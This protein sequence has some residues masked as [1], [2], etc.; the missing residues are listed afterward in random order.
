M[1]S[2]IIICIGMMATYSAKS[3]T[4]LEEYIQLAF[5]NNQSIR[6]Q[7]FEF[8]KSTLA[9]KEAK[10]LF[11]PTVQLMSDYFLAGGGRTVDFPAGDLLNP[12][13]STLNQLTNAN[14][15]PQLENQRIL[16]NPNNFY[17]VKIR[18]S[19]PIINP[20]I[21]FN[22]IIKKEQMEL[23][24]LQIDLYKRELAK[25]IKIAYFNYLKSIQAI[26]IYSTALTI[27]KESRRINESLFQNDKV[28]RTVVI[29][30]ENEITKYTS[31]IDI[32]T[33]KSRSAMAYFNFLLNRNL[34]ESIQED[35][36]F[37]L[38]ADP[39]SNADG[40]AQ[41][42]E[43]KQLRIAEEIHRQQLGL[44]KTYQTPKLNAFLDLGSQGFDGAINRNTAYYFVGLSLQWDLFSAGRNKLKSQQAQL[45]IDINRSKYSY[46]NQQFQL[47][48]STSLHRLAE[49]ASEY[50]AALANNK[51][52]QKYY[53]DILKL[54]KEGQVLYI[55]LLDAQNQLIQS[56]LQVNI[57]LFDTH[58]KAAEL[59]R[60]NTSFNL[61]K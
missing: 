33:Q 58:I 10:T 53:T 21:R 7:Y 1:K 14:N 3:Q 27:M 18:T 52:S 44:S 32:A 9:L 13:Y 16:L 8:E 37:K 41:R 2:V 11:L 12:V 59:E 24:R 19:A 45:D 61:N 54:Y 50:E 20:S 22:Q 5:E 34:D 26:Q 28:N 60:T 56:E 15:F 36:Q 48:H 57:A 25:E 31:L 46:V 4:T 17:D 55:E 35:P 30:A 49:A 47:Q 51:T 29:R 39:M 6:Q 43:L 38:I 42:E 23:Q 40:V